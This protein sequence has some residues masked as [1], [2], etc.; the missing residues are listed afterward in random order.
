MIKL[1]KKIEPFWILW[2][3]ITL[4]IIGIGIGILISSNNKTNSYTKCVPL[5][6]KTECS[7]FCSCVE[8]SIENIPR[9]IINSEQGLVIAR[10]CQ[11]DLENFDYVCQRVNY[12]E[13][14]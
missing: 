14:E 7:K 4:I 6:S 12:Y 5:S 1:E 3:A 13:N 9:I 2:I 10:S 8:Q 11:Y